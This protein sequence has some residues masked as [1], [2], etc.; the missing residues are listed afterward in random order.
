L[1]DLGNWQVLKSMV[2]PSK[3]VK[4]LYKNYDKQ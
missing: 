4:S 3:S 1:L 2:S